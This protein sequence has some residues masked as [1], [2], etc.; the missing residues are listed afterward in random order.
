MNDN[1]LAI[2]LEFGDFSAVVTRLDIL[3]EDGKF[4][5]D[6]DYEID[7]EH[8]EKHGRAVVEDM[9]GESLTKMVTEYLDKAL[10]EEGAPKEE[11]E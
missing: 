5:L 10:S 11:Q 4:F 1:Q 9:L 3:E 2:V 6:F 7:E 8:L